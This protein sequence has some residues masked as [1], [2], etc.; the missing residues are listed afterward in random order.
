MYLHVFHGILHSLARPKS[1]RVGGVL[2][3]RLTD[4]GDVIVGG[5]AEKSAGRFFDVEVSAAGG[6]SVIIRA[7]RHDTMLA[8]GTDMV[9]HC[10]YFDFGIAVGAFDGGQESRR[11]SRHG[12]Y[13]RTFPRCQCFFPRQE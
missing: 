7:V 8:L 6:T 11:H 10:R 4:I 13:H 9:A 3:G 1:I 12:D 5:G 2:T